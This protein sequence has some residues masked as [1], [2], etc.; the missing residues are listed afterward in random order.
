M[1]VIVVGVIVMFFSGLFRAGGYIVKG[2]CHVFVLLVVGVELVVLLKG[3]V[4][5]CCVCGCGDGGWEK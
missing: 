1:V 2:G 3:V 5:G 4:L